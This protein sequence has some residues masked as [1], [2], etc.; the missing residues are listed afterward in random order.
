MEIILAKHS[1]QMKKFSDYVDLKFQLFWFDLNLSTWAYKN[2]IAEIE[3]TLEF[4]AQVHVS[5]LTSEDEI[6]DEEFQKA[7]IKSQQ[8]VTDHIY[9]LINHLKPLT[10]DH[11]SHEII[12]D[13][14]IENT[15]GY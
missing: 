3:V 11:D 5:E 13:L 4:I 8:V 10:H 14:I 9:E 7:S 15:L 1:I 6:L 2:F 12:H